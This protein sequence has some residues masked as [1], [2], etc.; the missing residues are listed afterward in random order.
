MLAS[1]DGIL[2]EDF[3]KQGTDGVIN[4][5]YLATNSIFQMLVRD[6]GSDFSQDFLP[7]SD[8]QTFGGLNGNLIPILSG[9]IVY[10]GDWKGYNGQLSSPQVIQDSYYWQDFS[11]SIRSG[12]EISIYRDLVK[13]LLHVAGEQLFGEMIITMNVNAQLYSG[14]DY[15]G[16]YDLTD[17]DWETRS[18]TVRE[19][20]PV[21]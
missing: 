14:G 20:L 6:P 16:K 11:Y 15:G 12:F 21:V 2:I 4:V 9:T 18:D 1:F 5:P 3:I 19:I 7:A 17:R 8:V 10:E 13:R